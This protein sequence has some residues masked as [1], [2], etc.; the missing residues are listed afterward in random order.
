MSSS[1]SLRYSRLGRSSFQEVYVAF[2]GNCDLCLSF[3]WDCAGY[4]EKVFAWCHFAIRSP[5]S[6]QVG[7]PHDFLERITGLR[8]EATNV[9]AENAGGAQGP[10]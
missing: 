7:A 10:S 4:G 5:M 2:L 6:S 1:A 3:L 9:S 8:S